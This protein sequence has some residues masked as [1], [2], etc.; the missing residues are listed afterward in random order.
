MCP[1][2]VNDLGLRY[3]RL[4]RAHTFII[5]SSLRNHPQ[6]CKLF[7]EWTPAAA[8]D[9]YNGHLWFLPDWH[10]LSFKK[11]LTAY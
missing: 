3:L 10:L 4:Q 11:K 9:S 6:T 1:G 7:L 5:P 8:K 2:I